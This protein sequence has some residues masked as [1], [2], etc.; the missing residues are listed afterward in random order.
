MN[1]RVGTYV[2]AA[3]LIGALAA[4][5][6]CSKPPNDSAVS[7]QI[8]AKLSQ[9]S[10][11]QNKSITVQTSGGVVTLSG[12]VDNDTQRAA[13]AQYAST[14]PG[15]RTVVNNLQ[16]AA[17]APAMAAANQTAGAGSPTQADS[18]P[19]TQSGA[20]A[21]NAK[22]R[23]GRRA[24]GEKRIPQIGQHPGL[25][26][27]IPPSRNPRMLK[28]HRRQIRLQQIRPMRIRRLLRQ[29]QRHRLRLQLQKCS[30]SSPEPC[31]RSGWWMRSIPK[32]RERD[33]L[34][35]RRWMRPCPRS[36]RWRFPPDTTWRAT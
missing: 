26:D 27:R 7:E 24:A 34:S 9:D 5:V 2:W 36:G 4:G 1:G 10:G 14:I 22:L 16:V 8:Q 33:R 13:A 12:T 21:A 32:A 3:V 15:V 35:V 18:A 23:P 31:C 28:P 17:T 20:T 19:A 30:R 29:R 11:L 6:G 25:W